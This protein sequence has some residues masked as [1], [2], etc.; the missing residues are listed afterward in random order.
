MTAHVGESAE[1]GTNA[2]A[3]MQMD[4][5]AQGGASLSLSVPAGRSHLV[6]KAHVQTCGG[7]GFITPS[8]TTEN[9]RALLII[10]VQQKKVFYLQLHV[11]E[12]L[13]VIFSRTKKY[14][15]GFKSV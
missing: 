4:R 13:K 9:K 1:N 8:A 12:E 15:V 10:F 2:Q 7:N 3:H 11:E 6:P 5:A 14:L